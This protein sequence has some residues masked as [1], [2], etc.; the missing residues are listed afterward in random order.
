MRKVGSALSPV[1]A[2]DRKARKPLHRQ[3]YEALR[4]AIVERS[5]SP[6]QQVP[7]TRQLASELALSR[8][9]ILFAYSQLLAEGY[10][11]TRSGAGTFVSSSLPQELTPFESR[12]TSV[13]KDRSGPRP[14][15]ARSALLPRFR[16]APWLFGWGAFSVGQLAL[17]HFP[18]RVWS[19]LVNRY[20]RRVRVSSLHFSDP[21]GS[22]E[23]RNAIATYLKTSRSVNCEAEQIL[24]VSGSQQA[25][26]THGHTERKLTKGW[27]LRGE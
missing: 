18:F 13:P 23:F 1:I 20:N 22:P 6:S 8:V 14:I 24:V 2:V 5:L 19:G 4:K 10:L 11:E 12:R 15:S 26:R 27:M 9:P 7:S 21:M 16:P 25:L 3:V 17:D